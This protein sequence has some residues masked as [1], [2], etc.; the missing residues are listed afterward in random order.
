MSKKILSKRQRELFKAFELY[1]TLI[2]AG[3][4]AGISANIVGH[5]VLSET[6]KED[7]LDMGDGTN[8]VHIDWSM[9]VGYEVGN[10]HG[11]GMVAVVDKEGG[12]LFRMY[13]PSGSFKGK[14]FEI[15]GHLL[16]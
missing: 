4:K 8:H 15:G 9:L 2:F 1:P 12:V 7:R 14:I 6:S 11:E 3:G 16:S 5:F 10:F 13:N